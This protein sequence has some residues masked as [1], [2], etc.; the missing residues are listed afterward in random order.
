MRVKKLEPFSWGHT[1]RKERE[2]REMVRM[3]T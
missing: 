2:E 3:Q 1:F